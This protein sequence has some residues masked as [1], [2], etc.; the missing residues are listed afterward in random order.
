MTSDVLKHPFSMGTD[1][2]FAGFYPVV[3]APE[4]R[5]YERL[6]VSWMLRLTLLP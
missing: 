6:L 2:N 1:N 3:M 5:G 4:G